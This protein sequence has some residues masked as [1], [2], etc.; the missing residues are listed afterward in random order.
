MVKV[1]NYKRAL[2]IIMEDLPLPGILGRVCP[3][4]CEDACR[5]CEKDD[6]V[7]IRDLKRLAADKYDPR[8]IEISCAPERDERVA[9]I[10]SGPAGLSTAYFLAKRGIK[11]TIYEALPKAGGML[12]VGIPD[13]RLPTEILDQEIE[14][15]TNMGVEIKTNTPLGPDLTIE[16]LKSQGYKAVYL[17]IGAHKGIELGIP[18]ENAKGVRQG[19][20]F[21]RE[22]TLDGKTD[23]GK[24]VAIIGGGNVAI[25]VA[26]SAIRL[27]AEE[28]SIVYRRTRKEMPAFAEE[29][30]AALDE[31]IKIDY[32]TAPQEI[33]VKDGKVS[34][35]RCIK[36]ELGEPDSSGRRS[37]I[38]VPGS[39]FDLDV[40]Q[41]IPAIGQKPDLSALENITGL[42]F[43]RWGTIETNPISY[44]T[45]I[46]GVFAGGDVQTGPWTVIGA[47]ASAKEAAESIQR[48]F[49][50]EDMEAGRDP[51]EYDSLDYR[52]VEEVDGIATRVK[53]PELPVDQRAGNFNEVELGY[54][55]DSGT[56]EADRCLNC[57][58]C[59]DCELCVDACMPGAVNHADQE[60]EKEIEV[61]AV[62]LTA[63]TDIYDPE[64]LDEFY[65]YGKNPNVMTSIEF[66]RILS[67]TGPTSGHLVRQSDGMEPKSIAWIQCVGSRDEN[68]CENGYCSS[69]CCMYAMKEA[70]IAKEHAHEGLDCTIFNMDIRTFGKDYEKYYERSKEE[71]V[72]YVQARVHT[73]SEVAD[74]G[75]LIL[76]Y[77]SID[78][79]VIEEEYD[80]VVLS[81]GME[82]AKSAI[83]LAKDLG[84]E[85][86]QYN[87]VASDEMAPVATSKPGIYVAGVFQGPKDIPHSI[88]E[89]SAAACSAGAALSE[90]RGTLVKQRIFPEEINVIGQE[91]KIGVF[92][93]NC[94]VNIGGFADVPAIAEYAKSLPNVAHVEENLFSC[95]QDSQKKMVEVIKEQGLNRIVVAAC[96][97]ITHEPLF[98]ETMRDAGLNPYLFEM[99]NIRNQCT[100]VHSD[101]KA[102]ATGKAKDLVRMSVARSAWLEP[103]DYLSVGVNH[104]VVVI[105]GGVSGMNAALN[106]A[107]Q[108]FQT[109][110]V[111]KELELGGSAKHIKK[112]WKG[113]DV[114]AYLC[115]LIDKVENHSKITVMKGASVVDA[116]GF[117]GNFETQVKVGDITKT[118]EHGAAVVATGGVATDT[119][120]YLYGKNPRVTRWHD[121]DANLD[122][123]KGANNVV[124]IQ[125]VGSRDENRPYCSK[126]CCTAS[127]SQALEVKE[128]N[129]EANVFVLHRDIR[130][131]GEREAIYKEAREKGII[132]IR[133]TPDQKPVVSEVKDGLEVKVYEPVL[134]RELVIQAD[135]INL[136]TAIEPAENED[137]TSAYK[138]PVNSE[139]FIM[140]AHAKLRP[141]DCSTD[142]VYIC[143][144]AHYPKPMDESIS[145]AQASVSRAIN[146]LSQQTVNVEPIVSKI[147]QNLCI[148]CGLCIESCSFGAIEAQKVEG[149]GYRAQNISALCKGC[150]VCAVAC[151]QQAIEMKHFNNDQIKAAI[152]AGKTVA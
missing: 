49:D 103:L 57:S 137:V 7:A 69:V 21:L 61:G 149:L 152:K 28:V 16:D 76:K 89:A 115:D 41:I 19:V 17:S 113:A 62:I 74:T 34:G 146:V 130:T 12:R 151:P 77:A 86:N 106:F 129:P 82:P 38:P 29:I 101:D 147:D 39:E 134:Q 71:G 53:M 23:V 116:H 145:Q 40:D 92:V 119:E 59:C 128:R 84:I 22:F 54:D 64:K 4:G 66:E 133:Y 108:G 96:S 35:I 75:S 14:I 18:G 93:C 55:T 63:G 9:I 102:K 58:Y 36:M 33:L 32:L 70:V 78:G 120:E 52:P 45:D 2:E 11:S 43:S 105:G 85:L 142:G 60:M 25:D 135:L 80:M 30:Q 124:F 56:K 31:G 5:R 112:T 100:W 99:A 127:I 83:E 125:C 50:G 27:G 88:M 46:E 15:I 140:E 138:L 110:L 37:P 79:K 10:G 48:F 123:Y 65:L 121:L 81:V 109:T 8:K 68:K 104:P 3:H 122:K 94:G 90:A 24:K 139:R 131:Y 148:G 107:D 20:D 150:G 44:A 47:V 118:I 126:I 72:R 95:S 136:A 98:Q 51:I 13:H 144:M 141:V 111:E 114:Q 87:F 143:G 67:A 6:P 1:G 91:A 132:F 73:I 26:R 42:E 117:I 97:P